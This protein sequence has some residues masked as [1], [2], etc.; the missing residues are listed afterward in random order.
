[1]TNKLP[2]K[3]EHIWKLADIILEVDGSNSLTAGALAEAI[4]S[5][6]NVE[7]MN[8]FDIEKEEEELDYFARCYD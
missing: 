6:H 3:V 7:S 5:H 2:P 4:L 8:F 1:M